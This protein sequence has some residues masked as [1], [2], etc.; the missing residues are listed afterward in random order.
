ADPKHL[1]RSTSHADA[2][3]TAERGARSLDGLRGLA[4]RERRGGD[5]GDG[6]GGGTAGRGTI[7][8]ALLLPSVALVVIAA[9]LWLAPDAQR[10]HMFLATLVAVA[11]GLSATTIGVYGGILVPGL[12]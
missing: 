8:A 6:G 5:D 3:M 2:R 1:H 10:G 12:L 11:A 9:S 7:G 4:K